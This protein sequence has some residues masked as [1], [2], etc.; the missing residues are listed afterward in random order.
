[1]SIADDLIEDRRARRRAGDP[2][3][4]EK[5]RGR[6]TGDLA[7]EFGRSLE[8]ISESDPLLSGHDACG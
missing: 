8:E 4:T 7:E 2:R 6:T 1:M 3:F 5:G